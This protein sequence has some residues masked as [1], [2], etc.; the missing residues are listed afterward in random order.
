MGYDSKAWSKRLAERV[1]LSSGVCHFS[2]DKGKQNVLDVLFSILKENKL[3]GSSTSEGFIHGNIPAVCFQDAPLTGL[4]QNLYYEQKYREV[5]HSSKIRYRA[6]GI[7]FRKPYIYAKG[8][9]PVI[10][11]KPEDAKLYLSKE[12][13]WRIVNY[14]LS[15]KNNIIDWTHEREWRVPKEFI[16][17][18]KEATILL[19]HEGQYKKFMD[20]CKIDW[21]ELPYEIKGFVLLNHILY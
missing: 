4:C 19:V 18:L 8:G 21:P 10:Y 2:K 17:D 1:D 5:N 16:F 20:K 3:R 11:D 7:M 12:N 6:T 15:D 14:D 13:W 9:R